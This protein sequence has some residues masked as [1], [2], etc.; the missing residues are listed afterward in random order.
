MAATQEKVASI[1]FTPIDTARLAKLEKKWELKISA[2]VRK[3]LRMAVIAEGLE[4][5]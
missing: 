2:V 3:A 1:R 5:Q 4:K